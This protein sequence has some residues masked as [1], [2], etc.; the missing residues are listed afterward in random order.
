MAKAFGVAASALAVTEL[1]AKTAVRY[2]QY[3]QAVSRARA[4][5]ERIQNEVSSLSVI[6]ESVQKL[7]DEPQ[8]A[9]LHTVQRLDAALLD[10]QVRLRKLL[11]DLAPSKTRSAMLRFGLRALKWP[12]TSKEIEKMVQ[13][14]GQCGQTIQAALQV[15]QTLVDG[16]VLA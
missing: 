14:L 13:E 1:A 3:W 2:T 10:G 8:G 15:D 16:E 12:F 11:D 6:A 5:I 4:D 9:K 7:I